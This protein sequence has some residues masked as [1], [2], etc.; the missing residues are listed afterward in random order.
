MTAK[1]VT[2]TGMTFDHDPGEQQPDAGHQPQ[3][4]RDDPAPVVH[5]RVGR[6]HGVSEPRVIGAQR[7]LDLL[8]LA[9]LMLRERHGALRWNPRR[10]TLS[11]TGIAYFTAN[12]RLPP[13]P[14]K[15]H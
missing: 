12:V 14:G 6:S 3:R 7:L 15:S 10:A 4:R 8:E 1:P 5:P 2:A 13:G 11:L 9:P